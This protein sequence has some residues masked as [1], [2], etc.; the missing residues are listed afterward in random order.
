MPD[1]SLRVEVSQRISAC[2]GAIFEVLASPHRHAQF[3][4]SAMLR[5]ATV[6][7]RISAVGETF[8]LQMHRLGRDYEMI[9]HV[10][11]FEPPH[12]I[13][14]EPSPGDLETAGGVVARIGV[15]S[16]YRWGYQLVPD[17]VDATV[18]TEFFDCVVEQNRWILEREE[19]RWING[20]HSLSVSMRRSLTL[21]EHA[22]VEQTRPGVARGGP[23]TT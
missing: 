10:V 15:P 21:L 16:G 11:I 8:T 23:E 18:V 20:E 13:A 3:D 6:E 22:C 12:L 19:G 7:Q 14:W 17:G 1:E 5:G 2:A 9:N 4:G